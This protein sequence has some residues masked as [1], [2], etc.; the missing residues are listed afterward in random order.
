ME[1]DKVTLEKII[2]EMINRFVC[3]DKSI[4]SDVRYVTEVITNE[5]CK[6]NLHFTY[7]FFNLGEWNVVATIVNNDNEPNATTN[8]T[9]KTVS[10]EI[11]MQGDTIL[12]DKL[13]KRVYHEIEHIFQI[14]KLSDTDNGTK[15]SYNRL[16]NIA[17][18]QFND[19][20]SS[21]AD[22]EI[23]RYVYC[24]STLEQDAFVNEL[25]SD[26]T[27]PMVV[28]NNQESDVYI[29]SEALKMLTTIQ[30]VRRDI[31]E[32]GR[33]ISYQNAIA[34]YN[35]PIK[36]F[37]YLGN[38]AERRLKTKI[39]NVFIKAREDRLSNT[40]FPNINLGAVSY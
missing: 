5:L 20:K 28:S 9:T 26:L 14:S 32:N 18:K 3:E 12:K 15:K 34:K 10:F 21:I 6:G 13:R 7:E 19:P 4:S 24:C 2:K 22:K 40:T 17:L 8:V 23:A 33:D 31:M 1:L 25:Y 39:K 38:N 27:S 36:W 35:K 11:P 16:Y 29:N 37:I 30:E